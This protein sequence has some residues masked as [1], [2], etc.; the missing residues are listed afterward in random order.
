LVFSW[1]FASGSVLALGL[2]VRMLLWVRLVMNS[3][4]PHRRVRAWNL[5][6]VSYTTILVKITFLHK[7]FI[8]R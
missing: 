3:S 6:F 4:S 1:N 8:P 2:S 5:F 7:S